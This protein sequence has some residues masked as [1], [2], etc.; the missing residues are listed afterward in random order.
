MRKKRIRIKTGDIIAIPVSENKYAYGRV[1]KD[2]SIGILEVL[3]DGIDETID[4]STQEVVLVAGIFDTAIKSGEWPVIKNCPF[5]N[6]DE[7]WSPPRFIRDPI[8][9]NKYRIYHK[10][11]MQSATKEDAEGLDQFLMFKPDQLI[12]RIN[13]INEEKK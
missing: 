12:E 8:N 11:E 5:N 10:G 13:S 3:S 2:S 7:A 9:P 4:F 1:F 6:Q